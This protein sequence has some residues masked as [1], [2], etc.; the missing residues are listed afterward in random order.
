MPWKSVKAGPAPQCRRGLPRL[1][2][3]IRSIARVLRPTGLETVDHLSE[4]QLRDIGLRRDPNGRIGAP[5]SCDG[6]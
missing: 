4:H 5:G 2:S 6:K 1:K 3:V